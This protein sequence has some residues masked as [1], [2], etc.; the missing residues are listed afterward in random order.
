MR[1][2]IGGGGTD[3]PSYYKNFGSRF[4]SAAIN[5][6]IYVIV[7]E[8]KYYDEFLI[9]YSK[10]E[11]VKKVKEIENGLIRESLQLTK[12]E[13]P[14]EI[15]SISDI[16]GQTGLGSSGAF[17]VGLLKALHEYKGETVSKEQLAEEACEIAIN[18]LKLPSGKQ[19]EYIASFGGLTNFEINQEGRVRV[20][21][22][23]YNED[24]VRELERYLY[25]FYTGIR[26]KSKTVLA[27][28]KKATEQKDV[29]ILGNLG[30][31]QELGD[32]IRTTLVDSKVKDFGKLL[33]KHWL[34]KRKRDKT[35]NME[36]DTW[37]EAALK[38][39]AIGGKIMGAGG[40]GFFLFYCDSNGRKLIEALEKQG[41]KHIPFNID[42]QGTVSLA[43]LR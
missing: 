39:G 36:I 16:G 32:K 10:T 42:Y 33:H 30:E 12:I 13:Q 43:N 31:V 11:T 24:F 38:S 20:D 28:Q 18:R 15:V 35:T 23:A 25:M 37:Y 27:E 19:D 22:D 2:S 5:K 4:T 34:L 40:G 29:K 7:Q 17:T 3:L 9:K 8:R 26:R 14:L 21:K 6:Y 1:I 41:L